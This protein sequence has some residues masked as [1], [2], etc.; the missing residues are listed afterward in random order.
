MPIDEEM[1]TYRT[2]PATA[3]GIHIVVNTALRAGLEL[4][5]AKEEWMA[6][7]QQRHDVTQHARNSF[8]PNSV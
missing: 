5:L 4:S 8:L 1:H 7:E 6:L 2:G 3:E